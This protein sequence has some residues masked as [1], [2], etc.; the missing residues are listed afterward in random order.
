MRLPLLALCLAPTALAAPA[1]AT[2]QDDVVQARLLSGWKT[3]A[4]T[5]MAAL[6]LQLAPGWKTYWRSPGEAGIPPSFDWTGSRNIGAAVLHWPR[7]EVFMTS[8]LQSIGYHDRLVLPI[9][10]T[11]ADAGAPVEVRATVDL[12]VCEDICIPAQVHVE[13]DLTGP[14]AMDGNIAA[15]LADRP[16]PV[17]AGATCDVGPTRDGLSVTASVILPALRGP[18]VVVIESRE[19]GLWISDTT[20][21]R[22]GDRLVAVADVIAAADVPLALDRSRMLVTVIGTGEAVEI[23]GCPAP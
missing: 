4:G 17:G 20:S 19:P 12:G 2:T 21:D 22:Q 5:Y 8:G 18:E 10:I 11:P 13:T 23:A 15:A 6:E 3:K 9:E 16:R 14:G 1:L 7:P